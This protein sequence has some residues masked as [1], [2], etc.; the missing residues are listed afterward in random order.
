MSSLVVTSGAANRAGYQQL[1]GSPVVGAGSIASF[2]VYPFAAQ[3]WTLNIPRSSVIHAATMTAS[4]SALTAN[5]L[6]YAEDTGNSAALAATN[7]NISARVSTTATV[8]KTGALAE[9]NGLAA[10]VQEVVS[11]SDWQPGNLFTLVVRYLTGAIGVIAWNNTAS[12]WPTLTVTY[13]P[14]LVVSDEVVLR[15]TAGGTV[16][17]RE[18]AGAAVALRETATAGVEL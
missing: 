10:L 8:T 2:S 5:H 16:K 15:E 17:M 14:P 9:L 4:F 13:S 18:T 6:L 12:Q 3:Q 1:T 11:R 7:N